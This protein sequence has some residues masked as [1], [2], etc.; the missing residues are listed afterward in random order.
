MQSLLG[1][2]AALKL[3]FFRNKTTIQYIYIYIL[4]IYI[5]YIYIDFY[6]LSLVRNRRTAPILIVFIYRHKIHIGLPEIW[7]TFA[8]RFRFRRMF[9][10][11]KNQNITRRC[12]CCYHSRILRHVSGSIHL[13]FMINLYFYLNF[14]TY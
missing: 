5:L 8:I 10:I 1:L 4:Y 11:V 12:F 2:L 3:K 9:S 7:V 6:P 14:S 13:S